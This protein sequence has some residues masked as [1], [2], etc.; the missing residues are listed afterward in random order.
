MVPNYPLTPYDNKKTCTFMDKMAVIKKNSTFLLN[1][2]M[3]QLRNLVQTVALNNQAVV[4]DECNGI[5]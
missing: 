3:F 1:Y 2:L 4:N 5:G